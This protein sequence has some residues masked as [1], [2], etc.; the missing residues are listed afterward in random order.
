MILLKMMIDY[1]KTGA[2]LAVF[3][4]LSSCT[5][6]R[7][8]VAIPESFKEQAEMLP[9]NVASLGQTR[10][11]VRFGR[12]ITSPIQRGWNLK[13]GR[14]DRNTNVTAEERLLRAF[15]IQKGTFTTKQKH[16]FRF[17]IGDSNRTAQVYALEQEVREG[18]QI[19]RNSSWL[20]DVY[21]DKNMQYSFSALIIPQTA[22]QQEP[23]N[24]VMY[25]G[26]DWTQR[27]KLFEFND[28]KEGGMLTRGSDTIFIKTVKINKTVTSKGTEHTMP[29][30]LPLAYEM[31]IDDTVCAIIDPMGRVLWLYKELNAEMKLAVAAVTAALL[32][33]RIQNKLG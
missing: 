20:S 15:Q 2:A 32:T 5:T 16:R 28:I 22:E 26:F 21:Q 29:F 25:T 13:T 1:K 18:T 14:Y 4:L 9:I 11:P 30:A 12:Y 6:M 33:R 8:Q 24:F 31:R 19:T 23:W 17:T 10:K 7:L 3:A 27:K